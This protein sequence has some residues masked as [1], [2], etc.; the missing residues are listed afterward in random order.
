MADKRT[1]LGGPV[2]RATG[3]SLAFQG[4]AALHLKALKARPHDLEAMLRHGPE[5]VEMHCSVPD[6]DWTPPQRYQAALAVHLPEYHDGVLLDPASPHEGRRQAVVA[7]YAHALQRAAAWGAAFQGAKPKA[8]FHPGGMD[9]ER[10]PVDVVALRAAALDKTVAELKAAAGDAVDLLVENLPGHCHFFG[11]EWLGHLV[12][13]GRDL[14]AVC[15]KHG[16]GATLDLCHLYLACNAFGYDLAEE[17]RVCGPFVRH[18]HYSGAQGLDGEGLPV[19]EG[20]FDVGAA[21]ALTAAAAPK[22]LALAAVPE[23][24]FGHE[25]GGAKFVAAWA[26]AGQALKGQAKDRSARG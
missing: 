14:A 20:T 7:L 1:D 5:L 4:G 3:S 22:G 10:L 12:T 13:S 16:I 15:A 6:L 8:V 19:G 23:V 26:A 11:G 25:Q 17:I 21:L 2:E 18:V 24:W 9:V